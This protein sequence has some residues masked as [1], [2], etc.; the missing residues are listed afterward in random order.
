MNGVDA[1]GKEGAGGE[2]AKQATQ[3]PTPRS[4]ENGSDSGSKQRQEQGANPGLK[5]LAAQWATPNIP[6]RGQELSKAARP[7][8]GGI[9]LQ[10]QVTLWTTP[11]ASDG[12]KGGPNQSFGA[13]GTPLVAQTCQWAT[14]AARDYK[15]ESA[16][17]EF[18][19][20]RDSHTRGKA[21]SYQ[22]C[23][24]SLPAPETP[25]PGDTSSTDGSGSH[26]PW[27]TPSAGDGERGGTKER[28]KAG[29]SLRAQVKK[30]LNPTFVEWLMN[31]PLF[32][33]ASTGFEP[34]G[35]ASYLSRQRQHLS[36]YLQGICAMESD[37]T[38]ASINA[39]E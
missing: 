11:R 34:A 21:L 16:T 8:S 17:D 18:N 36:A 28:S 26:R 33:T 38:V 30:Q 39:G 4:G 24:S 7:E 29:L 23:R 31:L 10:S 35:M 9:D 22:V 2:F 25:T 37:A 14:P 12:E 3:W 15:S 5:D 19:A 6:N 32:W 1:T 20:E 13:G 27:Q